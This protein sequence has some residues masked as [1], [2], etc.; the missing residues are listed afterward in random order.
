M[1]AA[2]S[3][4]AKIFEYS[5]REIKQSVVG[6]GAAEKDQVSHMVVELLQLNRAPQKTLPML[7]Q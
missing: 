3:H 4:R 5:A 2:A 1:V 6:Y 7:W